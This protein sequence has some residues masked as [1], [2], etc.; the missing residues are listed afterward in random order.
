MFYNNKKKIFNKNINSINKR[1]RN[2]LPVV[3]DIETSGLNPKN[4]AL[5][6]ITIITLKMNNKGLLK[7]DNIFNFHIKPFKN[8]ILKKK[9]LKINKIDPFHPLRF[10][11]SEKEAL[12]SI[13][14]IINNE[15]KEKKCNKAILVG[16][17]VNFDHNFLMQLIKRNKIKK[18]PF[19]TF[20]TFDTATL[21]ALIVGQTVLSKS[22]K[23]MK[24]KFN[25]LKAHSSLY[26]AIKTSDLFCKII[27]L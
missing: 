10:A 3:I 13:L 1:F 8:S 12:I 17:N 4:N 23:A 20:T 22:C 7:K 15:I 19:H 11:I 21:S 16:H 24:I 14:Q 18:H 5:L 25:Y 26:D 2:F 6:E 27:N 9:S